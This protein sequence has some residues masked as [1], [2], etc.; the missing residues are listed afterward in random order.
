MKRVLFVGLMLACFL[1][2]AGCKDDTVK[3]KYV[4]YFIG[5]G[6]GVNQVNGTEMFL[7]ELDSVIGVKALNFAGFPVR[8]YAT[9]YSAFNGVTCSA[10]AGTALATGEKT[11]NYTIGMDR[12]RKQPLYSVARKAKDA[13]RRVGIITSVGMNHATP[14]AFYAH[15]PSRTMYFEIGKDAA[16]AGFDL[17]GGGG[18]IRAVSPND[19]LNL[20]RV[21]EGAGYVITRGDKMFREKAGEAAKVVM[22]Q[23]G[24]KS[25][26][27]YA[28]DRGKEDLTLAQMTAGAIGYLNRGDEGFFLMVEGGL[29]DYACH[30][31]DAATAFRETVDFADAIREAIQFYTKHPDETLIVVTA[32]HETGGI[33]LG[34]GSYELN[35]KILGNQ[36]ISLERL[37]G[38]IKEMRKT[39]NNKVSW[40]EVKAVLS[41]NLGFWKE[42]VLSEENERRLKECYVKTFSGQEVEMVKNL[43]SE[44]EPIA[45]LGVRVLNDMARVKWASGGHSAGVVPVYATGSGAE[46]FQRRLDNT[47]IPKVI[48][49][50]AGY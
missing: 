18:I 47:D 2:L 16:V 32:D 22:L 36:K 21:L 38:K 13:G 23:E 3:I 35:L 17:Y 41:E 46:R 42:V 11:K 15:Q 33:V 7:A 27:P 9:T 10:A 26:L 5:D 44:D 19:S 50:L 48:I 29:I 4:F 34:D 39:K 25:T 37:T 31:N 1:V 14:A 8:N 45:I 40:E 28:I 20:Y 6:M 30:V 24:E 49:E 43:Y 12:E